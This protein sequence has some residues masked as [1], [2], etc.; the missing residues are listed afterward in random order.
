[1]LI[2]LPE[3]RRRTRRFIR[4]F[5]QGKVHIMIPYAL[6]L[7]EA[8][9]FQFSYLERKQAQQITCMYRFIEV[10]VYDIRCRHVCSLLSKMV[11]HVI[12]LRK[13]NKRIRNNFQVFP[14]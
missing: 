2:S 4:I 12:E 3:T 6:V 14:D 7:N 11:T 10:I 1:M 13:K 8:I 9:P 5:T